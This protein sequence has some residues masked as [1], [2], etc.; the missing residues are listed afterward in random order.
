M[1]TPLQKL[2]RFIDLSPSAAEYLARVRRFDPESFVAWCLRVGSTLTIPEIQSVR[3]E[4]IDRGRVRGPIGLRG[5]VTEADII[6][7][8]ADAVAEFRQPA[9]IVLKHQEWQRVLRSIARACPELDADAARAVINPPA[10][11]RAARRFTPRGP[12][13]AA[14]DR[15]PI[16]DTRQVNV[17]PA[18][19]EDVATMK[20]RIHAEYADIMPDAAEHTDE[21]PKPKRK[22][23]SSGWA[24]GTFKKGQA[25]ASPDEVA[26]FLGL[27]ARTIKEKMKAGELRGLQL[28]YSTLRIELASVQE[29]IQKSAIGGAWK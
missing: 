27:S 12:N 22:C 28:G 16:E 10:A 1:N 13:K 7:A 26:A 25:Y 20:A 6:Q 15:I 8:F 4:F 11:K 19:I 29:L 17:A 5:A 23:E 3:W 9:G 2:A 21:D 14:L 24:P 18:P